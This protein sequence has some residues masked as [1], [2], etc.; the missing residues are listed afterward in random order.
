MKTDDY[1]RRFLAYKSYVCLLKSMPFQYRIILKIFMNSNMR[2]RNILRI[3]K[4]D[5]ANELKKHKLSLESRLSVDDLTEF[6]N[7]IKPILKNEYIFESSRSRFDLKYRILSLLDSKPYGNNPRRIKM[8]ENP[9]AIV[10]GA[11]KCAT[12]WFYNICSRFDFID[13]AKKEI[14]FFSSVS[15]CFGENWYRSNFQ[16]SENKIKIDVSVFYFNSHSALKRM[17][18]FQNKNNYQLKLI[19][20]LRKPS[21]RIKSY[22]NFNKMFAQ[23]WFNMK[24]YVESGHFY[25]SYF[26]KSD[27]VTG[28]SEVEKFFKP[29]QIFIVFNE[30][31]IKDPKG[32]FIKIIGFVDPLR[33]INKIKNSD[34]KL[35]RKKYNIGR[36]VILFPLYKFIVAIELYLKVQYKYS[37]RLKRFRAIIKSPLMIFR[38]SLI[39]QAKGKEIQFARRSLDIAKLDRKY[40]NL[41]DIL[42]IKEISFTNFK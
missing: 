4:S 17:Y 8:G 25:N 18:E 26:K 39:T 2:F 16:K 20:F 10:L 11:P 6:N 27:Y 31:L 35:F 9:N 14:E 21:S 41:K 23:G 19:V 33:N 22:L 40:D 32:C 1:L 29:E 37:I 24:K 5:I 15:Y 30:D 28:I 7:Y 36:K 42:N 34:E 38:N 3:K 13:E 12:T